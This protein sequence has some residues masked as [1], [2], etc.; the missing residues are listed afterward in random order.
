MPVV[1]IVEDSGQVETVAV[2][3]V[4]VAI[5]VIAPPAR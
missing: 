5:C 1:T 3:M 4:T 2:W